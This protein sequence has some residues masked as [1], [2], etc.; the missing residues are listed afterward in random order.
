[1]SLNDKIFN[2]KSDKN[3]KFYGL[4]MAKIALSV[5]IE[6]EIKGFDLIFSLCHF[7]NK[8]NGIYW[9]WDFPDDSVLVLT[10]VMSLVENEE[11][12]F[13]FIC[14]DDEYAF[15]EWLLSG[16]KFSSK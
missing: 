12:D 14:F 13:N 6:A 16:S 1:M 4:K 5:C 8:A 15:S 11:Q 2:W 3:C 10:D 7:Q 9:K